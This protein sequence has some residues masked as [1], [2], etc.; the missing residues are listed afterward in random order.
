MTTQWPPSIAV[1][2]GCVSE[3]L[4]GARITYLQLGPAQIVQ[5]TFLGISVAFPIPWKT[6]AMTSSKN[7]PK[8]RSG[9]NTGGVS[10]VVVLYDVVG[11]SRVA[12]NAQCSERA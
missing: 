1:R 11:F 6:R 4:S 9:Y 12:L 7:S 5:A 2:R 3:R 8:K 10:D